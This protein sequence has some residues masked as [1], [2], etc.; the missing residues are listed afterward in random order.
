MVEEIAFENGQMS[1]YE[2]LVNELDLGS[3]HTS[4]LHASLIDL[5]LHTK[6]H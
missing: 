1:N 4:Y 3:G 6:C 5:Y 2:G